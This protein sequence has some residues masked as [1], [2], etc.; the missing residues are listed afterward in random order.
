MS[1]VVHLEG[2]LQVVLRQGPGSS[3]HGSVADQHVER[4]EQ[5]EVLNKIE[6]GAGNLQRTRVTTFPGELSHG[7]F[8]VTV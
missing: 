3:K 4:P 7:V 1:Q 6:S 8:G 2:G 5:S